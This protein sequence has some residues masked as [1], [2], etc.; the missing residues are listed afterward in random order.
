MCVLRCGRERNKTSVFGIFL[1]VCAWGHGPHRFEVEGLCG[2][3]PRVCAWGHGPHRFEVEGLGYVLGGTVP[4]GSRL[5]DY[6]A[7]SP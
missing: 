3:V 1:R 6:A 2:T 7:R 5:K 4:I